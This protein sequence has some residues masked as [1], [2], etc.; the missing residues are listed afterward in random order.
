MCVT[1][2]SFM[3]T[4]TRWVQSWKACH[5]MFVQIEGMF[6][7]KNSRVWMPSFVAASTSFRLQMAVVMALASSSPAAPN[8]WASSTSMIELSRSSST[9]RSLRSIG[10]SAL[11]CFSRSM[12]FN[13]RRVVSITTSTEMTPPCK[14]FNSS[15]RDMAEDKEPAFWN[16]DLDYKISSQECLRWEVSWTAIFLVISQVLQAVIHF[17]LFNCSFGPRRQARFFLRQKKPLWDFLR[18]PFH[19]LNNL[20]KKKKNITNKFKNPTTVYS[21]FKLCVCICENMKNAKQIKYMYISVY[22]NISHTYTSMY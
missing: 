2:D 8:V 16:S 9:A 4:E 5:E 20:T 22:I 11:G 15:S 14:V 1:D 6:K 17:M 10:S 13:S 18:F 19:Q 12:A 3:A 7:W 21:S